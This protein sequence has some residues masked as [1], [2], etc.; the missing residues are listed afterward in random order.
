V[1]ALAV[2][3][4]LAGAPPPADTAVRVPG[5]DLRFGLTDS[6]AAARGFAPAG[7]GSRAGGGTFFGIPGDAR[8]G[9]TDG[10]LGRVEFTAGVASPHQRDY[11]QDQLAAMGYRRRCDRLTPVA[12]DCEWT[13]RTRVRL[14]LDAA[15]LHAVVTP[16][17]TGGAGAAAAPTGAAR[18]T[19]A[20]VAVGTPATAAVPVLP[21]TLVVRGSG[22]PGRRPE[23]TVRDAPRCTA[24]PAL[25]PDGAAARVQVLLLVD[26]DGRVLEATVSRGLPTL[27]AAALDCARRWRF[28]PRTWQG[29]PC[30][31][32]VV[33]PVTVAF[34]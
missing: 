18:A 4:V 14:T 34:D 6:L 27:D 30:R 10:R 25:R 26:T 31:Y 23:A 28:E 1:L 11:A 16:R 20:V 3:A 24:P 12:S 33:V 8:L 17:E 19:A 9:F 15:G 7:T 29:A 5:T 2:L 21:E 13:G 32:R 22:R